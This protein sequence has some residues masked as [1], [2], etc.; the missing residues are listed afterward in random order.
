MKKDGAPLDQ[1]ADAL[2]GRLSP[3]EGEGLLN[4]C[5]RLHRFVELLM[6]QRGLSLRP[7]LGYFIAMVH[8]LGLVAE[9]E[10]ESYLLRSLALFERETA[11]VALSMEERRIAEEALLF[12]HRFQA[13][14]GLSAEAE[15]FRQA[16]WIEHS[17]GWR[18][19]GL[20]KHQVRRV[21]A[22]LPRA[23]LDRVLAD[24]TRRVVLHE[25]RTL[26]RG[27]FL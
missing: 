6:S 24:F 8:D 15:C 26:W 5:L 19:Y 14:A 27:I 25:P 2:F 1:R 13:V 17:R 9:T 12:N 21:F 23:N 10:G 16:V 20:S 18:R 11:D 7:G 3:Y 22:E 4:H